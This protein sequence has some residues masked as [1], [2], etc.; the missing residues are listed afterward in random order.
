[1]YIHD[2]IA[3]LPGGIAA[4]AHTTVH[5]KRALDDSTVMT[6]STNADGFVTFVGNGSPGPVYMEVEVGNET[7]I[8]HGSATNQVG[9][10]YEGEWEV[11]VRSMSD[12]VLRYDAEQMEI[13]PGTGLSVQVRP[14][15]CL[16]KGILGKWHTA[17]TVS[18]AANG[19]GKD[20]FDAICIAVWTSGAEKGRSE[21]R[22]VAGGETTVTNAQIEAARPA[23]ATMVVLA[24]VRVQSG[25]AVI[26][27]SDITDQRK[28]ASGLQPD[29]VHAEHIADGAVGSAHL[30]TGSVTTAKIADDAI[31]GA[32]LA[33]NAVGSGHIKD[34]NITASKYAD[35][36]IAEA[37]LA[38]AVR[39]KLNAEPASSGGSG[40][41]YNDANFNATG[42]WS[43]GFR[44]LGTATISLTP[45][46]WVLETTTTFSAR[47]TYGSGEGSGTFTARL[48][49]NGTPQGGAASERIFQTVH[50]VPRQ[51]ILSGR[52]QVTISANTS[53]SASIQVSHQ[54]G[55][56]T[57]FRD[58]VVYLKAW[59]K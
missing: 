55:A 37:K 36:S 49:G 45:G 26:Q 43:G 31:T 4:P 42:A 22:V 10:W 21:V 14:G 51:I 2:R 30:A 1:M 27:G 46:T 7:R 5:L 33:A 15:A 58:G 24:L 9:S 12:G 50:G 35:N 38:K 3:E 17:E 6:A 19:S 29:S 59:K 28:F 18:L 47:G 20:R 25:A 13:K 16:A 54:S 56:P 32:K 11:F 23:D 52:R 41:T 8:R 48:T 40:I 44:T 57:D 39:D 53:F 34:G